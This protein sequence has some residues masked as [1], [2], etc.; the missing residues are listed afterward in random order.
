MLNRSKVSRYLKYTEK[1]RTKKQRR[2]FLFYIY[3]SSLDI[4][5]YRKSELFRFLEQQHDKMSY[6]FL[7]IRTE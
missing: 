7:F 2:N 4:F 1:K 6:L 3:F 5:V